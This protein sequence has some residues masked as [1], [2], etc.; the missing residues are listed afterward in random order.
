F[1]IIGI[2][3]PLGFY[4]FGTLGAIIAVAV[5]DLPLYLVNLWGLRQE[6]LSCIS[7][8]IR[9]TVFFI[10][11]LSLFIFIRYSLGFGLPIQAIL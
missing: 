2:G 11:I 4:Y 7:Q 3:L 10:V 5:G 9:G 6:K 1:V 8:D